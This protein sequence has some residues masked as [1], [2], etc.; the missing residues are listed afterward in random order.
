MQYFNQLNRF[1]TFACR[2]QR[3]SWWIF[4]SY[5]TLFI[6]CQICP[7]PFVSGHFP[8]PVVYGAIVDSVC[9]M[10]HETCAGRGACAHYDL[11]AF[12]FKIFGTNMG[13]FFLSAILVFFALLVHKP[14]NEESDSKSLATSVTTVSA[15]GEPELLNVTPTE[16]E[17]KY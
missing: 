17:T 6:R 4:F 10:W 5:M 11:A 1:K 13:L 2:Y 7:W 8:A 16:K 15:N 14:H 12:R 9:A 3:T